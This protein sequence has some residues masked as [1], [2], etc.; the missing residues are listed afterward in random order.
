[1]ELFRIKDKVKLVK[2]NLKGSVGSLEALIFK[3]DKHRKVL[4]SRRAVLSFSPARENKKRSNLARY[5]S[6]SV[7]NL[8]HVDHLGNITKI[9]RENKSRKY[10]STNRLVRGDMFSQVATRRR[11]L[12][13]SKKNKIE[14]K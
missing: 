4:L 8:R 10:R 12:M 1:M 6:F 11:I 9:Y 3:K 13:R 2:G 7:A 14:V 5:R